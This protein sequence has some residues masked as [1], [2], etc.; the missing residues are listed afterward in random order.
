M[1]LTVDTI[2]AC[3]QS[4]LERYLADH[5]AAVSLVLENPLFL[6]NRDDD[7]D[8]DDLDDILDID[9][10]GVAHISIAGVLTQSGPSWLDKLFGASGTSYQSIYNALASAEDNPAVV[11]K[12]LHINSPGGSVDGGLDACWQAIQVGQKPCAVM[13]DGLMASAAYWIGSAV[14]PGN[15]YSS[16]PANIIGSIGVRAAILDK[17][18]RDKASGVKKYD[19]VSKNAPNKLEDPKTEAGR[20]EIQGQIDAMERVFHARVAAGRGISADYVAEKF[21]QGGC[22]V[23]QDPDTSKPCA[24]SVGMIDAISASVPL[25][26][27]T[28]RMQGMFHTLAPG[29][30]Y[31]AGTT[32]LPI[33]PITQPQH[34]PAVAGKEKRMNLDEYLKEN[35]DAAARVQTMLAEARAAGVAEARANAL[36]IGA[37]LSSDAYK[38][39]AVIQTKGLDALAGKLSI[40]AFDTIVGT[41]DAITAAGQIAAESAAKTGETPPAAS[42]ASADLIAKATALGLDIPKIQAAAKAAGMDPVKAIEGNIQL[43]EQIASD[44]GQA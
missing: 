26:V 8:P 25:P 41:V 42:T 2:W 37:I 29:A 44:K 40:E 7:E 39:N 16:S 31:S 18:D 15:I 34:I 3:E 28:D 6:A 22:F 11:Q 14:G 33:G 35:P 30:G 23:A 27:T 21:G 1:L 12:V 32:N 5:D 9:G 38:K 10:Q 20:K 19:F 36:K 4:A 24:M 13:V 17:S 43:A